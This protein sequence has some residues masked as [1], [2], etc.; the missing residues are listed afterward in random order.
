MT[1]LGLHTYV[2]YLKANG[3]RATNYQLSF[4]KRIFQ[5]FATLVMIFLAVPFI[6]GPLRTV[7]M[8]MRI[9][10][11]I[12][13]GFCFY[14][15]NQFFGPLSTLFQISPIIGACLPTIVFI[16]AGFWLLAR[17]R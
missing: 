12:S 11:G 8:G 6:F 4:W 7:T 16:F 2:N 3:L 5:P 13:V 1:L 10:A 14:I 15:L 9:L 17:V